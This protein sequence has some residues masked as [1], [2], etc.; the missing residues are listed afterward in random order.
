MA[1]FTN[2]ATLSYNGS[3]IN[4]NV[5]TGEL[6]DALTITKTAVSGGYR[7]GDTVTYVVTLSNTGTA[8]LTGLTLT[9]DLGG[10]TVAAGTVY[11]LAYVPGSVLYYNGGTA[12]P[13]PTV[14][15]GP[16]MTVT[17]VTVPAGG[18]AT[19][20]YQAR[21]T[22]FAAPG[23]EGE[24]RN[25]V[26]ASGGGLATPLTATA[27]TAARLEPELTIS[28]ALSPAVV[29]GNGPLTYTFTIRNTGLNDVTNLTVSL[30]SGE[31]ATLTETLLPNEST[32]LTVWHRVGTSVTNPSYTIT[33]TG[34][35]ETGTVYLDYPDIGISQMEVIVE[36]A[37]K[38]TVRMTL[39]NS[40]AATLAGK[41]GREVKLAFYADDL[42][43]KPAEVA[44]TT[45]DVSVRG[46][47]ITISGDS[48]LA[49]IDQGTFTL[50]LTYDLGKYM[51][52]IGKTEIPNVG[53]YLYAEAW[54]E[55]QIGGTGSN[56]RLPEYD[57]SDSEASVHIG[58]G[59]TRPHRR[60]ADDGCDDRGTTATVRAPPPL[61]CATTACSLR[62]AQSW[63]PR[64]WML[65][66]P[67]WKR[68][69][70]GLA[71]VPSPGKP[72]GRKPSPSPGLAPA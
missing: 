58:A 29:T 34:I 33:A 23:V 56:Q 21:V 10:S 18:N 13:A 19:L 20:V 64:C 65:P 68:K 25:T 2:M 43:T 55:G 36:S 60:A 22:E 62:L 26:T 67:F 69:R 57:G 16:P 14:T 52:S 50:D 53:T 9:D 28:K 12:Q 6:Q 70:P 49:R 27:T 59:A 71:V 46:N 17:G 4:S 48:A 15:A 54:A 47:E 3:Q 61:P 24:I 42:H 44:C 72:S 31:T 32:T 39:Y 38:R 63:W 11:P 45:N 5:V 37:G 51:K 7:P 66:G 8:A 35:N 1:S 40:S 30:G 41:K